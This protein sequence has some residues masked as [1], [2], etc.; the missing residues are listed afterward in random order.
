MAANV[1]GLMLCWHFIFFSLEQKPIEK[2][3]YKIYYSVHLRSVTLR[4][5]LISEPK[6]DAAFHLPA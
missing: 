3:K 4:L 6:V 2:P 5:P 1:D